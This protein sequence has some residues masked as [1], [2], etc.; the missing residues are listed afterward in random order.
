MKALGA[1][2]DLDNERTR[3]IALVIDRKRDPN[4]SK[5]LGSVLVSR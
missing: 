5:K 4:T 1:G 2:L 3:F